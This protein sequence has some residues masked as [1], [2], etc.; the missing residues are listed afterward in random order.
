MAY[1][2]CNPAIG[3]YQQ[4]GIW[5]EVDALGGQM[6][7]TADE[8][9]IQ[10]RMLNMRKGQ[11]CILCVRRWTK[12]AYSAAMRRVLEQEPNLD[13]LQGKAR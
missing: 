6:G 5:C 8:T 4:R 1:L 10:S 9:L 13:L 3:G 12:Q 7:L 2:P 11:L